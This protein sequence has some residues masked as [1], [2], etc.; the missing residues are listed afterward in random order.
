MNAETRAALALQVKLE[1]ADRARKSL[2]E[3]VRQAWPI[4]EPA[5][6]LIDNWHVGAICEHLE[7]VSRSEIQKLVIN[8]PPGH[9]K[10]LL[11]AVCWPAWVWTWRPEWRALFASYAETLATR[12]AKKTRRLI[13]DP[14]YQQ[15]F[16]KGA[17]DFASDQNTQKD[18]AN[19]RTGRRLSI[20]VDGVGTGERGNAVVVDDP[21]NAKEALSKTERDNVI[22]WWDGTMSS[23]VNDKSRD[24]FVII[25]QRLHEDD[26]TGHVLNQGG[27]EHLCLPTEY[28]SRRKCVTYIRREIQPANDEKAAAQRAGRPLKRKYE[29]VKFWEDPR[30]EDGELLFPALFGE[31]V[32]PEIK[33]ELQDAYAGQHQQRPAPADGLFFKKAWWNFWRFDGQMPPEGYRRPMGCDEERKARVVVGD[34]DQPETFDEIIISLD[35]TFKDTAKSDY[36]SAVV[37][38]TK[39]AD[40]FILEVVNKRLS[41]VD[42]LA[43]VRD[44]CRRYPRVR[45]I[46][47]EDKANGT[48]VI[49]TLSSEIPGL[50]PVNPEGGKESRASAVQPQIQSGNV[51]LLEGAYWLAPF[52]EQTA[53]F[54]RTKHDDMVDAL[55]QGITALQG[56]PDLARLIAAYGG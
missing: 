16:V 6:D 11:V 24:S 8:V 42:T 15:G 43:L 54:P 56:S 48:A 34:V 22:T 39:R 38:G 1:R 23:R 44:L 27:Y 28:E 40:R 19:T 45:R 10:S 14:W 7:A 49:N 12:D 55:T 36:V 4:I 5:Y 32:L 9:A 50:I 20:G 17:W 31:D 52:V 51:Y 26:L 33:R 53:G 35:C 29:R 37:I 21:I 13:E 18:Y 2:H 30:T 41:F 25:M 47:V 46:F 3:F